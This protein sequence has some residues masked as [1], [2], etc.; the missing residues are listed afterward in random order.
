MGDGPGRCG[1]GVCGGIL[2]IT[3]LCHKKWTVNCNY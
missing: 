1:E 3:E 2:G